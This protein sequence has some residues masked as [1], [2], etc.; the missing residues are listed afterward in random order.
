MT[1]QEVPAEA[2]EAAARAV[3]FTNYPV[4]C[5]ESWDPDSPITRRIMR[6][7]TIALEKAAPYMR[8]R[9]RFPSFALGRWRK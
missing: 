2:V 3:F 8:T 6:D 9:P 4:G 5:G 1:N 7:T